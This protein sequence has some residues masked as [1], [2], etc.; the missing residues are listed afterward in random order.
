MAR[1]L[2]LA[3]VVVAAAETA[4]GG[5]PP[6]L[7]RAQLE[8]KGDLYLLGSLDLRRE[9]PS[10]LDP[11]LEA[12]FRAADGIAVPIDLGARDRS[13][14]ND[15]LVEIALLEGETTLR[16]KIPETTY[17]GVQLA[18][19]AMQMPPDS[20]DAFEPWFV[21]IFLA[22][23]QRALLGYKAEYGLAAHFLER[24]RGKKQIASL[25]T[26]EQRVRAR[27]ELYDDLQVLMLEKTLQHFGGERLER[28]ERA[29]DDGDAETLEALFFEDLRADPRTTPYF[30]RVVFGRNR[31]LARALEAL[32][33]PGKTWL[34]VLPVGHLVGARSIPDLLAQQGY[35]VER[36]ASRRPV[37]MTEP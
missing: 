34:A 11:A 24:A 28:I 18:L 33:E 30:E 29:W 1:A 6:L 26:H 4:L 17:A 32:L 3:L 31:H 25:E 14:L 16:D 27:T 10:D 5:G 2:A 36:L 8:G 35:A 15:R 9:R 13:A 12:A 21:G 37:E 22:S 20:L 7:W 19:E 23:R